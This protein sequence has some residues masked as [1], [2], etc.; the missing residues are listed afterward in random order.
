MLIVVLFEGGVLYDVFVDVC[1]VEIEFYF[2][3]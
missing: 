2:V 3:M 1:C